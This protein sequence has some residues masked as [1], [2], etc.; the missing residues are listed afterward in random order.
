M[1]LFLEKQNFSIPKYEMYNHKNFGF[2]FK[3]LQSLKGPV[4]LDLE[5]SGLDPFHPNAYIRSIS[6]CSD[7][8][9]CFAIDLNGL[10]AHIKDRLW[11]WLESYE[12][13][14]IMHNA[15]F[16]ATWCQ[17]HGKKVKVHRCS[18]VMFRNTSNEGFIGQKWELKLAM[19]EVLGWKEA[20][21]RLLDEWLSQQKLSKGDMHLS[22]WHILGPYNALD[23]GATYQLYRYI[24]DLCQAAGH[25]ELE[26][27]WNNDIN[28]MIEVLTEQYIHGLHVDLELLDKS[29]TEL[30]QEVETNKNRFLD[31]EAI[32]PHIEDFNT[33][34]IQEL[35]EKTPAQL[36]KDGKTVSTRWLAHN[37][38]IEELS[39]VNQ[40]N[41]NSGKHLHWLF[42]EKLKKV[43]VRFVEHKKNGRK[44]KTNKPAID[45]KALP[46]LGEETRPLLDY[47]K[48]RGVL[49]DLQS[50]N[51]VQENGIIHPF[52]TVSG[53]VTGRLS[54][55]LQGDGGKRFNIQNIVNDKRVYGCLA[56]PKGWKIIYMDFSSLEPHVL[57]EFSKDARLR[58]L[59]LEA[60]YS[61]EELEEHCKKNNIKYEIIN[62][63][64]KIYD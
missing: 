21:T 64:F 41:V 49:E 63:E 13:G 9:Y 4:A 62:G 55:G 7:I 32:K 36:L 45:K 33:T 6:L 61:V 60:E 25:S 12:P 42:F 56:A 10:P 29:L 58:A 57:C 53:T 35:I 8:G 26:S 20:N 14:F 34:I 37:A 39:K 17:I 2:F 24:T 30:N 51:S 50:I 44:I 27:Y 3:E 19:E 40:F 15:V 18:S 52:L 22:P 5:T 23:A 54:G 16:D 1:R 28:A 46:L 31:Q 43:P 48:S 11:T 47:R 38:K 59:Y